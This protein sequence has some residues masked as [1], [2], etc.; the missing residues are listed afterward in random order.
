MIA[1]TLSEKD[2]VVCL[3]DDYCSHV[4]TEEI[5]IILLKIGTLISDFHRSQT[6]QEMS[7]EDISQ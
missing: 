4:S 6:L 7:C 5:S 3:H 2:V 1:S